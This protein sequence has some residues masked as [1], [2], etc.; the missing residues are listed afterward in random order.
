MTLRR[1]RYHMREASL[2]KSG[3]EASRHGLAGFRKTP[4]QILAEQQFQRI[5]VSNV[6]Q[7]EKV[8]PETADDAARR[9]QSEWNAQSQM[10]PPK[11]GP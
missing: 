8:T 1:S 9:H 6:D 5:T 10:M 2:G 11:K 3:T 4:F 7:L